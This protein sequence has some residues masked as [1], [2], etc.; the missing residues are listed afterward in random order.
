[1]KDKIFSL[2]KEKRSFQIQKNL[3]NFVHDNNL[4]EKISKKQNIYNIIDNEI[5][6]LSKD[7]SHLFHIDIQ[8]N[9]SELEI[10]E[11]CFESILSK[12]LH[13]NFISAYEIEDINFYSMI[14]KISHYS[15]HEKDCL[16]DFLKISDIIKLLDE[17]QKHE[18]SRNI[19]KFK[20]DLYFHQSSY[21]KLST[22]KDFF[23]NIKAIIFHNGHDEAKELKLLIKFVSY[24][25]VKGEFN[26]IFSNL[27]FIKSFRNLALYDT[28][29]HYYLNI[30]ELSIKRLK[31][32]YNKIS[33]YHP[34][35]KHHTSHSNK[36]EVKTRI[37]SK[38]KN[39][40]S[41]Q[42]E[43]DTTYNKDKEIDIDTMNKMNLSLN[44]IDYN[45]FDE[46]SVDQILVEAQNKKVNINEFKDSQSLLSLQ[47]DTIIKKYFDGEFKEL[48]QSSFE[49]MRNDF[50]I[51]L[52]T[53]ESFKY[54][55]KY[56]T[57]NK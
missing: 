28:E 42:S 36:A 53:I 17:K 13:N 27:L 45:P 44:H 26:R 41:L 48:N 6:S 57:T 54:E 34:H 9:C 5:K 30:I 38:S 14:R 55:L 2:I 51:V 7:F 40:N 16:E 12:S 31:L 24:C 21:D 8:C 10:I 23:N 39:I 19:I 20:N 50:K 37:R 43:S 25:L 49:S 56:L 22:I 52:K 47:T 15:K 29:S 11:E 1:M 33:N 32:I 3:F 4:L 35:S 18:I 46:S